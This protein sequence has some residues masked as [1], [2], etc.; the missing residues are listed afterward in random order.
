MNEEIWKKIFPEGSFKGE[1]RFN[2]PMARHTSFRIGG[3]AE[4]MVFPLNV[5][6]FKSIVT[7][8]ESYHIPYFILGRGTNLLVR[9]GGIPG[10][11]IN[12]KNLSSIK[13]VQGFSPHVFIYAEAG[14]PLQRLLDF[15]AKKGLAGLEFVAGIP[16]TLGGAIL[17]NAGT[18]EGEMKDILH[19][20]SI[21][22]REGSIRE[23][24][25]DAITFGYR[26]S[27]LEGVITGATLRLK[28]GDTTTIKNR[29]KGLL[30]LRAKRQPLLPSAGSVF[31]NPRGE[32]AGKLI[33]GLGIKGLRI[34]DAEL[35]RLHANFIVNRGK[36]K[37]SDVLSLMRFIEDK[38]LKERGIVLEPEIRIVGEDA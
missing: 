24:K 2:E 14:V 17:M 15:V 37:A 38:V 16:G 9:D 5:P 3:P 26:S 25:R 7:L 1:V 34:G 8:A 31:K 4:V 20:V 22:D 29:I 10:I 12:L 13:I 19:T 36:A 11:T 27:N 6:D 33:E 21:M 35:S 32:P 23:I 28:K 18:E 30:R